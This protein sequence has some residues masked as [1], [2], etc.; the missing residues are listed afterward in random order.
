MGHISFKSLAT[1]HSFSE[2]K[3]HIMQVNDEMQHIK[4]GE[5]VTNCFSVKFSEIMNENIKNIKRNHDFISLTNSEY[6]DKFWQ[7][8]K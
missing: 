3:S 2:N 1:Y 8:L 6:L 5:F 7:C 4:G